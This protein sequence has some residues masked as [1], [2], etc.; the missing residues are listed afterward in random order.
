MSANSIE[1]I[2]GVC[3]FIQGYCTYNLHADPYPEGSHNVIYFLTDAREGI[4][5]NFA[6]AM[7]MTLRALNCP[8][9]FTVGYSSMPAGAG[10]E[11]EV[12][13][14][15]A[16]AWVE[17]YV[18]GLGWV[19][20]DPTP[21]A[22]GEGP[23]I[24]PVYFPFGPVVGEPL[25]TITVSPDE[26][27]KVYDGKAM[28]VHLDVEGEYMKKGDRVVSEKG[29]LFVPVGNYLALMYMEI[30]DKNDKDVTSDYQGKVRV[31]YEPFEITSR[32][33]K[34]KTATVEKDYDG[35]AIDGG[36]LTLLDDTSLAE[37]HR[38]EIVERTELTNPGS[39]MNVISFRIL[40]ALDF[41]VT[42][43]YDIEIE[44]G[45]LTVH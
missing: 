5:N 37:G 44:Y 32:S 14:K 41:D 2:Q 6:S 24:N 13:A 30:H 1:E 20:F 26:P 18:D 42:D 4:C 29:P 17:V 22:D 34:V 38:F 27:S 8:A 21:S 11:T 36:E 3:D 39:A 40:D 25:L 7:V 19:I 16:H 35:E 45:T 12:Q 15:Q 33:I 23:G 43:C 28:G 9:R 31:I 10:I